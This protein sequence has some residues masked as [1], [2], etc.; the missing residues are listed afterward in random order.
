MYRRL[1]LMVISLVCALG[2]LT[3]PALATKYCP[4]TSVQTSV[5]VDCYAT[6]YS[7]VADAGITI[8]IY[9]IATGPHVCSGLHAAANGGMAECEIHTSS[10][11]IVGCKIM[12][13]GS[14]TR[15][16]LVV[17]QG[18]FTPVVVVPCSP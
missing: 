15:L 7:T 4:A 13:E 17:N 8:T 10:S 9:S 1:I 3:T 11:D 2:G 16:S 12:G 14:T 5:F 6:N 18:D